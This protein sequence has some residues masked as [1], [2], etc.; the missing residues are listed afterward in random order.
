[1]YDVEC[2]SSS[3]VR[4]FFFSRKRDANEPSPAAEDSGNQVP[5]YTFYLQYLVY[6]E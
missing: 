5:E 1:M 3:L 2:I 4:Y 6:R